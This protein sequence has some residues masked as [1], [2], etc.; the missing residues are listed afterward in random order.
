MCTEERNAQVKELS[1]VHQVALLQHKLYWLLS[2]PVHRYRYSNNSGVSVVVKWFKV[3]VSGGIS[4]PGSTDLSRINSLT[5][6]I[7]KLKN[8]GSGLEKP[9]P[10]DYFKN[11][12][13]K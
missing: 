10:L 11:N 8:N 13:K 4:H 5:Y 12:N 2:S 1:W 9:D 7:N 6:R 3:L